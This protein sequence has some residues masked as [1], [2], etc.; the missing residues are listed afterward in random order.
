[1]AA[2]VGAHREK[3]KGEMDFRFVVLCSGFAVNMT[4]Y[5]E[6]SINCP[7]LHIFGCKEGKDRQIECEASR[8]LA[9]LFQN[10]SSVIIEHDLGH[11]IPTRSP[12][13]DEIKDFLRTIPVA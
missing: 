6:G 12:Y 13:I 3:L 8:Q 9:S 4:E 11:I 10:S 5:A 1:M 2:L 7:S